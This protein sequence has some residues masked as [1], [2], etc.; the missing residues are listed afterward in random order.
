MPTQDS[1][2]ILVAGYS[3]HNKPF[4]MV[5]MDGVKNYLL[6]LQTDGRC[7][8]RIGDKMVLIEPGDLLIY[9]P[10]QPYELMINEEINPQGELSVESGDYHIFFGGEWI[11]EWWSKL[12]RPTRI[13][14][15]LNETILGLF[16]QIV[17]EQRKIANP[18]PEILEYYMRI[19]CLETDRLL[20]EHPATTPRT[21][22]A[23]KMKH[24]IEENAS[25]SFK[26]EDVA[27]HAGISVSRAVHLFKETFGT[28]IMQ[29]TL[30]VRLDMAKERIIFSPMSLETI[31]ETSG[32]ANYTYFHRVFRSRYGTSPR[33]F[34]MDNREQI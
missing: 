3:F 5:E 34:R 13:K 15:P 17:L 32:F 10:D 33:K 28:S 18:Y 30:D 2:H 29:Y 26:L 1:V 16:R 7:R 23:Y 8:A 20:H 6:R 31:A 14:V 27:A 12:N 19:L 25:L 21:Y 24:Y 9:S 11:D 4:Y 22:M